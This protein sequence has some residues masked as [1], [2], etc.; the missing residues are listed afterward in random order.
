MSRTLH[1]R[2]ADLAEEAQPVPDPGD[3]WD[4]GRRWQRDRRRGT[5]AV[6]LAAALVL[7][8]LLGTSW[9][10][11]H[12]SVE[13][14]SGLGEPALPDR[15]WAPGAWLAGT[16][17]EPAGPVA[18]L[19]GAE[20]GGWLGGAPGVVGVSA[21]DGSYRFLDLPGLTA[22]VGSPALSPDGAHVAYWTTGSTTESPRT[23]SGPVTGVAVYDTVSGDVRRHDIPTAHGLDPELLTWVDATTLALGSGQY[24]GGDDDP[25]ADQDVVEPGTLQVWRLSD[26]RPRTVPGLDP[27]RVVGAAPRG[28]LLGDRSRARLWALDGE[29]GVRRTTAVARAGEDTCEPPV[30]DPGASRFAFVSAGRAAGGSSCPGT[31][32]IATTG[33]PV[34][35]LPSTAGTLQVLGWVDE[36]VA[37]LRLPSPR[38]DAAVVDLAPLDGGAPSRVLAVDEDVVGGGVQVATDLLGSPTRRGAEPPTPVDPRVVWGGVAAVLVAA[39]L[40]VRAWRRRAVR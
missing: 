16:G 34:E 2:L 15:V 39:L 27:A 37:V 33:S 24:R 36:A 38:R 12:P 14:A 19:V 18:V 31:V 6:S 35:L 7:V 30:V 40:A 28:L 9:L 32:A 13:P 4:R 10:R 23:A 1:D 11:S 5:I 3:A 26:E 8:V 17:A 25:D 29:G 22:E 21:L 20:R